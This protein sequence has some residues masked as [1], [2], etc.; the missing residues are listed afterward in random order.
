MIQRDVPGVLPFDPWQLADGGRNI[1]ILHPLPA[2]F[3]GLDLEIH[4]K[5]VGVYDK[6]LCYF[7]EAYLDSFFNANVG[8]VRGV[9][10]NGDRE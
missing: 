9:H 6:A 3:E 4:N 1:E 10:D 5:V 2:T 7:L 8:V